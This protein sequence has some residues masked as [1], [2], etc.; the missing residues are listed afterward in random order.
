MLHSDNQ[1]AENIDFSFE[2]WLTSL[3]PDNAYVSQKEWMIN[4]MQK[5][6][7]TK[8]KD[9]RN[10]LKT[11]SHLLHLI[12]HHHDEDS[13]FSVL[14]LKALLLKSIPTSWHHAY[15][16]KGTFTSDDYCHMIS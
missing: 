1:T 4:M 6:Y 12:L 10:C 13:S 15:A 14:D 7:T 5:P 8:V 11:L 16:L 3:L 9:F 2:E